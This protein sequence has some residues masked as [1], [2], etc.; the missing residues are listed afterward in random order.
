[1]PG[2]LHGCRGQTRSPRACFWEQFSSGSLS[3]CA[4]PLSRPS[5]PSLPQR[6]RGHSSLLR[7]GTGEICSW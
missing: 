1:M 7:S 4:L 6:L 2:V 3:R 5:V